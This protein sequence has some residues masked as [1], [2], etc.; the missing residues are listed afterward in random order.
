[1]SREVPALRAP[2]VCCVL[3]RLPRFV[4]ETRQSLWAATC[5]T[6]GCDLLEDGTPAR[7]R[8][9]GALY[10]ASAKNGVILPAQWQQDAAGD[11]DEDHGLGRV[12]T[13]RPQNPDER[14]A[15]HDRVPV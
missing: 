13:R 1:M 6:P 14:I 7:I 11:H 10:A 9:S 3:H 12:D 2:V 4:A 5:C 8:H 15:D